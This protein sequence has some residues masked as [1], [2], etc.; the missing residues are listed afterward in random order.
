MKF[1]FDFSLFYSPTEPYGCVTGYVEIPFQS[2]PGD[3]LSLLDEGG[4]GESL[5]LK[6]DSVLEAGD[7]Y[8]GTL[9]LEDHVVAGHS[10]AQALAHRLETEGQFF[11]DVY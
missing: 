9:M 6:I 4:M 10:S 1:R 3:V 11:V 8:S 7:D 2:R 5:V